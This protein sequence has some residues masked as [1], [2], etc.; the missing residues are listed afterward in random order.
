MHKETR[1]KKNLNYVK[2]L[3]KRDGIT[4]KQHTYINDIKIPKKVDFDANLVELGQ[5]LKNGRL[6]AR[7]I[8]F[9]KWK[10]AA[11]AVVETYRTI[12]AQ[13][14]ERK[15]E[16]DKQKIEKPT[17]TK[18]QALQNW[19]KRQE[20]KNK[21]FEKREY[22]E[23]HKNLVNKLYGSESRSDRYLRQAATQEAH[24][25]KIRN[26]KDRLEQQKVLKKRQIL[27]QMPFKIVIQH[28]DDKL[29]KTFYSRN[30]ATELSEIMSKMNEKL[31]AQETDYKCISLF[32]KN[33]D[34][35][36]MLY[37]KSA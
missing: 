22:S 37:R 31:S 23:L 27:E 29:D 17:I 11:W 32:G 13:E 15:E 33:N 30:S 4:K 3:E 26:L 36:Q 35:P 5:T 19:E 1:N 24:E 25:R 6:V 12:K 20:H 10:P 2:N 8:P 34:L 7:E 18:E 16:Q 14:K 28:H 21:L 9:F